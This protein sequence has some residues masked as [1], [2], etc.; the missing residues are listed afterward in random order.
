MKLFKRKQNH[1]ATPDTNISDM[2]GAEMDPAEQR[3]PETLPATCL[4]EKCPN[5]QG[6]ACQ[7]SYFEWVRVKPTTMEN[8][9]TELP[10]KVSE[11]V[12][13]TYG[14]LCLKGSGTDVVGY[15]IHDYGVEQFPMENTGLIRHGDS[16]FG[17]GIDVD[18]MDVR[19]D[20]SGNMATELRRTYDG[21]G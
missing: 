17:A 6:S 12:F 5:Y 10:P 9:N 19:F 13:V 4:G 1:E 20:E 15:Q 8:Q 2:T 7:D 11:T 21:W 16:R 18:L 3:A 14:Q